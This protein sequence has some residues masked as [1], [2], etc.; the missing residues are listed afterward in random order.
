[1]K[2][3]SCYTVFDGLELLERA[4]QTIAPHV[5]G[6][7]ICYQS[8]SNTGMRMS[9]ADVELL[10]SFVGKHRVISYH[11]RLELGAKENERRKHTMMIEEA[12]KMGG[13][14]FLMGAT[15]H[16]Y[17][18]ME[19]EFGKRL[20]EILEYDATF[21]KMFTYFKH[22]TWQITPIEDYYTPFICRLYPH[23]KIEKV[24]PFPLLVDPS[25]Q[26]NTLGKWYAFKEFE[27][28][29][30]HYSLV[31]QDIERKFLNAASP[32]KISQVQQFT[33]ELK[34]YDI[35]KNPG[36]SYFNGRFVQVVR[37]YFDL[38]GIFESV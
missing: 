2:L 25:V 38:S 1:M 30:H 13:T 12:K 29:M 20:V 17:D 23:T 27:V 9:D 6:V 31:R 11:T 7:V 24:R 8:I 10:K 3:I 18:P 33:K 26:M 4:I 14:H 15:D 32:W 16:F 28:M 35:K 34:E 37:D 19:F 21:T 36:I 5:D 22:P